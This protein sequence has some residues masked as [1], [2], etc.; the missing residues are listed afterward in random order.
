M[1]RCSRSLVGVVPCTARRTF[2]V[3]VR[4]GQRVL[5]W[6]VRASPSAARLSEGDEVPR[7]RPHEDVVVGAQRHREAGEP[8]GENEGEVVVQPDVIAERAHPWLGVAD[9]LQREPE[10]GTDDQPE[11]GEGG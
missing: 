2:S 3:A 4:L 9:S 7:Y 1:G 11:Q 5:I 8:A 6:K 10:R